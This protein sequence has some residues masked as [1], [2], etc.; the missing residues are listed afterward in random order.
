MIENQD[1]KQRA[2]RIVNNSNDSAQESSNSRTK[3]KHEN[4][5][6]AGSLI[7]NFGSEKIDESALLE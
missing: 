7:D 3:E 4:M 6:T 1:L 2:D 5:A